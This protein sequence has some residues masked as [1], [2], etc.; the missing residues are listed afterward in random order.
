MLDLGSWTGPY[1]VLI[2]NLAKEIT[3]VDAEEKALKVLKN[4]LPESKVRRG[5]IS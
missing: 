3:A 5:T 1:A 4:E 2:Y